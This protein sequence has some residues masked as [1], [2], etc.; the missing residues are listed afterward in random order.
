VLENHPDLG[1]MLLPPLMIRVTFCW[2]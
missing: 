2:L 1:T